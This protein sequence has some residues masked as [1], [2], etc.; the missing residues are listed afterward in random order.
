MHPF[1]WKILI[2]AL[3]SVSGLTAAENAPAPI[4]ISDI[5]RAKPIDF[6]TEIIPV[7]QKN[8]LPCHNATDAKGD[9][10]L[11]T[12]AT[13][14]K[15]GETGPAVVPGKAVES[16]LLKAAA[17]QTKPMMPPKNNKAN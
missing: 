17:H 14:L 15:G 10:V 4:S 12:P 6:G 13:I 11:E 16:L 7:F 3:L 2:V 5:K 8:C 9:L 1:G